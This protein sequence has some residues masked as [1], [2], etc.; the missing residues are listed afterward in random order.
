MTD[1]IPAA[2]S[3]W[4][5]AG[6]VLA[7]VVGCTDGPTD[8]L[9]SVCAQGAPLA[10]AIG[11]VVEP[12]G[13]VND[14]V[15]LDGAEAPEYIVVASVQATGAGVQVDVLGSGFEPGLTLPLGADASASTGSRSVPVSEAGRTGASVGSRALDLGLRDAE[16][17]ELGALVAGRST[18]YGAESWL[19][20]VFRVSAVPTEGD[21]VEYPTAV[22][23]TGD[24]AARSGRVVAVATH[25]VVVVDPTAPS[26]GFSD[27]EL[28]AFAAYFDAS[29]YPALTGVFGEISDIDGNARVVVF[30]T[31]AANALTGGGSQ[32]V[33]GGYFW[34]GSLFPASAAEGSPLDACPAS[35]EA[36]ILY[37]SVP[38]P[39]GAVGAPIGAAA[40]ETHAV[41][42]HELQHLINASRRLHLIGAEGL[43]ET[44][45]NEGLSH[46]AE[47]LMFY[48]A[49]G[50]GARQ[51]LGSDD[52][53]TQALV[54]PFNRFAYGNVGR[55]NVFLQA[56]HFNTLLG[57]DRIET[58]GATWSYL[59]YA[60]DRSSEPELV[61]R[62]LA[63]SG[64]SGLANLAIALGREPTELM[65]EWAVSLAADDLPGGPADPR[66]Q[67]ASWDLKSIIRDIRLD[68][69]YP[70]EAIDVPPDQGVRFTLRAG[71]AGF[72]ALRVEAGRQAR[73][74]V[75][76]VDGASS[77]RAFLVRV[78]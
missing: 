69:R 74:D 56:P 35:A 75:R 19:R 13:L 25:A 67:Q 5:L 42:A 22:T 64:A 59:R 41:L 65:A 34:A 50:V 46:L 4:R 37:M 11:E 1:R 17:R 44:W 51:N 45:L 54:A 26:P 39:Q 15:C 27:D 77:V 71:G 68:H 78:R 53:V 40:L 8:P 57:P 2:A 60:L 24:P 63:S 73:I 66:F 48:G 10:L 70:L 31:P 6:L 33:V 28:E 43:E 49:S 55:Y 12:P 18:D 76:A 36:E 3:R 23:C 32:G 7:A 62:T 30:F 20:P 72:G 9:Q 14:G 16:S 47:E 21:M 52:L 58:R 29:V 61:L 38:D